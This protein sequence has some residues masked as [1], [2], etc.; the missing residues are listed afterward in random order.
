MKLLAICLGQP[1][2]I[3]WKD[4]SIQTSIFKTA[5]DGV[6]NVGKENIEGDRQA[7]LRVHGGID[8]AIYAYSYET[9]SWWKDEL[10]LETLPYGAMGENLVFDSL[11]EKQI[12]VGDI[13]SIGSCQ[14]QAVQP[15]L[16]CYKLE[17]MYDRDDLIDV[18]FEFGRSGVYFRVIKEGQIKAN[19]ELRLLSSEAQKASIH[20]LF[21]YVKT[22]GQISKTLASEWVKIPS[23]TEFWRKKF[24][25]K[26]QA[27]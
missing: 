20:D 18:F 24:Q 12:Y 19:D 8:K 1:R 25:T 2:T 14:L 27:P 23:M 4:R 11:N 10:G 3:Q 13:F 26:V 21:D 7:D 5:V 9:Y 16:P 6:H 15:R 17:A 22:G